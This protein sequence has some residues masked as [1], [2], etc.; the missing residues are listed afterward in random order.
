[1]LVEFP[2]PFSGKGKL[3]KCALS[4]ANNYP[5][6][7]SSIKTLSSFI[8]ENYNDLFY[9]NFKELLLIVSG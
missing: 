1:V 7:F 5:N 9:N 6:D 2:R 4:F 8:G 3:Y